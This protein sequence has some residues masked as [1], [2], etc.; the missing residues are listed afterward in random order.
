MSDVFGQSLR[1]LFRFLHLRVVLVLDVL[2]L[3]GDFVSNR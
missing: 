1:L 3:L 2:F